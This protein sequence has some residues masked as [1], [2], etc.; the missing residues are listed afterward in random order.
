MAFRMYEER[1]SIR[2]IIQFITA[3]VIMICLA[4]FI[5]FSFGHS[6]QN[7]GQSMEPV[8][9]SE[10]VVLLDMLRYHFYMPERYDIIAFS[11][12]DNDVEQIL[13]GDGSVNIKRIIGL[14]G[15]T[16]R[17][18]DGVIYIDGKKLESDDGLNLV[19]LAGIASE[20]IKLGSD[21]FFVLGDNR[22]AS[23][24]SRFE[25]VGNIQMK[26]IIGKCWLIRNKASRL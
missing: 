1:N 5:V 19:S 9:E 15:E 14:P 26:D 20:D 25:S 17:I 21:E 7:I 10:D 13:H 6:A 16:V 11:F 8:L 23:E 18:A 22:K 2:P 3:V 24:D 4:W 12:S